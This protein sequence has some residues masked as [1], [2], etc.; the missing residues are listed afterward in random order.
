[1]SYLSGW[2]SPVWGGHIDGREGSLPVIWRVGSGTS[3]LRPAIFAYLASLRPI[4][5]WP[6]EKWTADGLTARRRACLFGAAVRSLSR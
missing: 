3:S 5:D 2:T 1:M 6:C 4:R